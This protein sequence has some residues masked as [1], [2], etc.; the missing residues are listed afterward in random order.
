[1]REFARRTSFDP[2]ILRQSNRRIIT[3][4]WLVNPTGKKNAFVEV[5]LMQEHLNFWI[6]VRVLVL[7]QA[8]LLC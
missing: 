1:M 7:L 6:K 8:T 4:N 5:D 2:T 3:D